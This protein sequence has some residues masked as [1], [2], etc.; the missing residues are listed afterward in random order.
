MGKAKAKSLASGAPAAAGVSPADSLGGAA[1]G[2]LAPAKAPSTRSTPN[3]MDM[4]GA[5]L[6]PVLAPP[7]RLLT[8]ALTAP[9]TSQSWEVLQQRHSGRDIP[10][11]RLLT[12]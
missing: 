11:C 5:D 10:A 4:P 1:S 2:S 7:S 12:A 3:N 9:A 8:L 6:P